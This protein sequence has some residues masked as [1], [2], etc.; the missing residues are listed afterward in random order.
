MNFLQYPDTM[1]APELQVWHNA[2][3]DS[4]ESVGICVPTKNSWSSLQPVS[5]NHSESFDSDCSK[6]NLSPAMVK[7]PVSVKSSIPSKPLSL[8]GVIGN[9]QT[10]PTKLLGK[11]GGSFDQ[12]STISK[13][14]FEQEEEKKIDAEIEEIEKEIKRLSSR[15]EALRLEKFERSMKTIE[16]RGRVV[17]AKFMEAKVVK[18]IEET[19]LSSSKP[20]LN[21]RGVSLGPA[22]IVAGTRSR[23]PGKL[24]ITPLQSI[25]SRRKS[26]FWKLQEID[27]E[28]DVSERRKSL[29]L[30]PKS[31]LKTGGKIQVQKQ[32]ATTGGSKKLAKKEDGILSLI[33]PR[34]LFKEGE[35]S[36]PA[37]KP[38]KQGRVVASR[39]N[40]T[41]NQSTGNSAAID[42]RKRSLPENDKEDS[43]RGDKRLAS[44]VGKLLAN[45]GTEGRIKKKW[46]IPA[47]ILMYKSQE[48]NKFLSSNA[49]KIDVLPK[50]KTF[51]CVD[52]S[53]RD[54]GRAK[55]AA[56]L[57]GRRSFFCPDE[58]VD[59]SLCQTVSFA[60]EAAYEE[61]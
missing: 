6:E 42:A 14:G 58:D 25:Q 46:E 53:P 51:R 17:P 49:N 10:K 44:S 21:R 54:S 32:A 5:E 47:E 15:L 23:V 24:E 39:Y 8:N 27:E 13:K 43:K 4:E 20:K 33:Q 18:K 36:V 29:S 22:E 40:Q 57:V 2:V 28:K 26:C 61:S 60:E 38:L 30:S 9:S 55:K 41:A 1:N 3:F 50:I 35:K 59:Q 34:K 56:E 12:L 52:E 37:K 16:R 7:S 48:E 45:Q 19:P 11:N 31:R